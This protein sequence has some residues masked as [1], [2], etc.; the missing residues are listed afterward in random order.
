MKYLPLAF[1]FLS[2]SFIQNDSGKEHEH[3]LISTIAFGSCGKQDKPQPIL[4]LAASKKPDVFVFLGDNI[5]GDTDDMNVLREKYKML[6]EKKEFKQLCETAEVLA[7]WDDHDYGRNDAGRHYPFKKESKEIFLDFWKVPKDDVRQQ[8]EGI[9][10]SYFYEGDG[11]AVQIILLDLRYFR[12][13]LRAYQNE[14]VNKK[15]FH[16]GL[17]YWSYETGDSSLLGETQWNWL[18]EQFLLPADV[19]IIASSTQFGITWNSYEAWA[20][21]L[22]EQ[23]RMLNLIKE[24]RASGVVFISGD[25]H[26]AE[27]SKLKEEGLYPIYDITSS[28]ITATW[29]FATPN[30]NRVDGAVMENHFGMIEIDWQQEDPELTFK[31]IDLKDK[32]RIARKVKLSELSFE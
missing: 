15:D 25:V 14:A 16:Y 19:R 2:F 18:K 26:Y 1:I 10:T 17:D 24:T 12:D 29:R 27:I 5:Y 28:G 11:R 13:N 31:I 23:R 9:Y 6:G 21:F 4:S 32:V 30:F 22:Q 8:R 20:N 3:P 7:I